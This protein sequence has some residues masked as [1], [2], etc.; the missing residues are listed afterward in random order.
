VGNTTR[1]VKGARFLF[2]GSRRGHHADETQIFYPQ[3]SPIFADCRANDIE[4]I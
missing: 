1:A 2:T 3:I 4:R